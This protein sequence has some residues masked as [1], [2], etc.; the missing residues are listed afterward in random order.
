MALA[1]IE[2]YRRTI[3]EVRPMLLERSLAGRNPFDFTR[4]QEAA[5]VIE[6]LSS[7]DRDA[8]AE[9]FSPQMAG[10]EA[11][12]LRTTYRAR[13]KTLRHKGELRRRMWR[14]PRGLRGSR[15]TGPPLNGQGDIA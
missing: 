4:H 15:G 6:K 9:A 13:G 10:R 3:D 8:W 11:V 14:R 12:A 1:G 7:L 2:H 5:Q